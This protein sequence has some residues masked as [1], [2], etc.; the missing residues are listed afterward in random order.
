[1][2]NIFKKLVLAVVTAALVFAAF[3]VTSAFAADDPPPAK[4]EL[5]T[6]RL[7]RIWARQLRMYER[8]G[9]AFED[10]DAH[11]AKFQERIDKAAENGKDVSALQAALDAYESAL[12]AAKPTYNSI[13]GIVTSHQG[14]DENGKVTDAE[15]AKSTVEQM[16]T[17]MQE[18][19]STVGDSF[20]A[21]RE[22][23]KAFRE[24]NK[25][26]E[27]PKERER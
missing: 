23:L 18:I 19:K 3:P 4:G 13:N 2:K 10:T 21:L 9:K 17:K 16:R 15:Q 27:V 22:A 8:L 12:K 20:K 6:E 14:F 11:I 26:A 25:P 5:T 24:A 7:E 1:M